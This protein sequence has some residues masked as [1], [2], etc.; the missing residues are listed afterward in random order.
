MPAAG[1]YI[2]R[3]GIGR[4]LAEH[5]AAASH[6]LQAKAPFSRILVLIRLN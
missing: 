2:E 1:K 5:R 3:Q 6:V 4:Q